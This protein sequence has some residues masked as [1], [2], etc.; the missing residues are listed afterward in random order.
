[1]TK[2]GKP[3]LRWPDRAL[4]LEDGSWQPG[5]PGGAASGS[6]TWKKVQNEHGDNVFVQINSKNV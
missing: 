6:F 5:G 1:M 2:L 3:S 4:K